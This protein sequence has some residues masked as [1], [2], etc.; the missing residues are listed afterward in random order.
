MTL[1][2]VLVKKTKQRGFTCKIERAPR[3][4]RISL[5]QYPH[6][7]RSAMATNFSCPLGI[8]YINT[9]FRYD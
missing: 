9:E 6:P 7:S 8:L 5:L 1:E 3:Y 4:P 2:L